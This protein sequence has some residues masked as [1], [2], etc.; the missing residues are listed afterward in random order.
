M[1]FPNFMN[2]HQNIRQAFLLLKI[3]DSGV[4]LL[5][6]N[7]CSSSLKVICEINFF[8]ITISCILYLSASRVYT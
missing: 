7:F 1:I 5:Q 6:W 2:C 8:L 3:K 4:K